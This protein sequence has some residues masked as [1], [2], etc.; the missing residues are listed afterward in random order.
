MDGIKTIYFAVRT[1]GGTTSDIVNN[2]IILDTTKPT[3]SSF[4]LHKLDNASHTDNIV[5]N[6]VGYTINHN[7]LNAKSES[8]SL[9]AYYMVSLLNTTPTASS[10][11][12]TAVDNTNSSVGSYIFAV[13]NTATSRALY[14]WVK[15]NAGNV[16][17]A[18]YDSIPV[19]SVEESDSCTFNGQTVAHGEGVTA[20][21]AE[22]VAYG[23]SCSSQTR[24]CSDGTLSGD[25]MSLSC[26][27][28]PQPGASWTL[29]TG[30]APFS[31]QNHS[32]V[33]FDNRIWVIGGSNQDWPI[34]DIYSSSN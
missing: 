32:S 29:A 33:V 23:G 8:G 19:L 12:W 6:K 21:L 9:V 11:G 10:V 14:V 7:D 17:L 15:D 31:L 2:T 16:S 4:F 28:L 27:V 34:N 26:E 25:Y 5:D 22:S 3:I 13:D 18:G 1:T 24:T 30:T 20:Y